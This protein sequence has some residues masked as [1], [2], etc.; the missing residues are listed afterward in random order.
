MKSFSQFNQD[1]FTVNVL[2]HKK[3]GTFLEIG[4]HD[5]ININNTYLLEK[6]YGYKGIMI[7]V[8]SSWLP[9]YIEHRQNSIHIINDATKVD[10]LKVL[11]EN[12]FPSNIDYLQIDLDENNKSSLNTLELLDK[13]VFNQYTFAI[14]HFEHEY[15]HSNKWKT[16]EKSID[17]LEKRGYIKVF[18]NVCCCKGAPAEDWYVHPSLVDMEYIKDLQ[19]K[20]EKKYH[21]IVNYYINEQC[22]HWPDKTMIPNDLTQRGILG[23][24]IEY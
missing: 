15:I 22:M 23:I 8:D 1:L 16:K 2:K 14:I 11:S 7:E 17:I 19:L 3:N 10:Y 20:N 5:A 18:E 12:N 6:N 13:T 24:D 4:S 9:S 21:T